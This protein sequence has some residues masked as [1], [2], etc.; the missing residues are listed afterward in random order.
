[1]L[2]FRRLET[3]LKEKRFLDGL[4][5]VNKELTNI[6]E[7]NT[8][9]YVKEW[10]STISSAEEC[11]T[12]IR[13]T[14]EGLMHQ[15][16]A[17]L[18]RYSY[19]KFP[20]LKSVSLY[21]DELIDERK[22][23]DA[24]KLLKDSLQDAAEDQI[25][26]DT[27]S[28]TYFTLVRC[29]LEMKRNEEA[30]QYMKK[31]EQYSK[32]PLFDKWGY[33]Y[34]QTGEWDKAE[35][36]LLAGKQSE[37]CQ[38]LATYLLSQLYAYRGE[39]QQALR[40]IDDAMEK[41]PQVPYFYFEKVKNLVDLQCYEE[42]IDL[43]D[44]IN[45]MLPYHAYKNYFV[46]LRAEALYKMNKSEELLALLKK[47]T[48]LKDSIYHNIEKYPDGKKVQL[49][50]V[51][52]VQ[53]DN[54]CVP[55]SLEM[56]LRLW[57][58]ER[59]Q[60][61]VANHIFDV[62]GSKFSD[63]VLYLEELGYVCRYFKG[64]EKLYKQ[65]IDQGIPVLLSLDIEHASHV[66]VL[67]GYDEQL[68]SFSIQDP[69]F[70][71]PLLV[72]Y[73]KFQERYRYTDYLSIVFVPKEKVDQ[74]LCLSSEEDA[75]FRKLFTLTDHLE[76]QDKLG[77]EKLVAFLQEQREI[78]YT[79]LYA[80]KH[81]DVEVNQEFILSCV[82]SLMKVYPDSDFVK[83][84][85][86]Q[87]F[88][89]LRD[90]EQAADMLQSVQKKKNQALY[91]FIAGRYALEKENYEEAILSFQ[92]SLQLDAD[93]PVAWS[94]LALS[95]MYMDQSEKGL[96]MSHIAIQRHPE[97]FVLVNHGLILMDLE[98][99]EQ[100]YHMFNTLLKD[101]KYEAHI[102]YERARCARQL[103]KLYLAIKGLHIAIQLDET[104]PYSYEELS[105][106]YEYD[107]EDEKSAE[108]ILLQGISKCEDPSTIYV[109][110]GDLY[111]QSDRFDRAEEIY[112]RC[113]EE[114]NQDVFAHLGLVQIYMAQE[115]YEQ[116]KQYIVSVE[117]QFEKNHDFL[118]NAGMALW[119]AEVELG[120]KEDQLKTVLFM[121]EDGIRYLQNNIADV[122]EEYV[123]RIEGTSFVQ[124]SIAFLKQLAKERAEHIE[125]SC[126][127]GILYESLGQYGQAMKRYYYAI[128][129]QS[130][131]LPY[132]RLGETYM[133][134]EQIE[135]AKKAYE[136]C[137]EINSQFTVGHFKLAE[138]YAMEE[139]MSKE[140]YHMLQAMKQ[141]P[142]GVDMEHLAQLSVEN[143]LHKEL[144]SELLKLTGRVAEMWRL[145]A[146]AYVYGAAG[147]SEK[148]Q[149]L[150]EEALQMDK[151]HPEVIFHYAKVLA[152]QRNPKAI[153]LVTSVMKRDIHN[154]RAFELYVQV[155]EQ[156]RKLP[157]IRDAL[158][159]LPITKKERSFTFMYTATA[160]ANRLA[161]KQQNEQPKKSIF[162]RAFYRMKNR[163]KEI[164]SLTM[165]IDLFE[166]SL[167]LNA[168][169]SLAA[170]RLA[171]FYEN[172]NMI[173]EAIEVLQTALENVWDFDAAQQFATLL[174][175]HGD[176][177][178]DMIR[179]ALRLTKQM[180][181]EQPHH[182]DV[183]VLQ[184]HALFELGDEKKA[185]KI[186][187]QLVETMP[188]VSRGFLALADIYRSQERFKEAIN[189]LE[190]GLTH[191]PHE[192]AIYLALAASYHQD[193]RT[194]KAEELMC[195]VLSFDPS[196]LLVR[197]N[198]ACYLAMLNRNEEAKA[199]LETVLQEDETGLFAEIAEEDEDLSEV[200]GAVKR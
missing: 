11:Y 146:L 143:Q 127:V 37:E 119:D 92:S 27:L 35:Q 116:A 98:C 145:D 113:L 115:Q 90:M 118:I 59:T 79:W 76:E 70:L 97:R 179:D 64:T 4:Y 149:E 147:D 71:E 41:F 80:I 193:G 164:Y 25:D 88:I 199:E 132:Y 144:L 61:E 86:A 167:K 74:L 34:I 157:Q 162:T 174:L 46:H 84:H 30:L 128:N 60:D 69:N 135:Q 176:G 73:D 93:Q 44:Q 138:I 177:N 120:A 178:E 77:I 28:K 26:S 22:V 45:R 108:D 7:V 197:Y 160:I 156:Q 168:K 129:Q 182:Y 194:E 137:L 78:P 180:L 122:L 15:Y 170:Q 89:R 125:Y 166:T 200:W 53:K 141:D 133:A 19:K 47:E 104:A 192:N 99:Y 2:E 188:F 196:D 181:Q 52:I 12:L 50:L 8:L 172:G 169:N 43:L 51:P 83:L 13:L 123:N 159:L 18:T 3:C 1:M 107:L 33:F 152:K 14:D 154:E 161:E 163:A 101:Y 140:Q 49:P 17:F 131:T 72:E 187:L 63:T 139:N 175:N 10:L 54:Y 185:E 114:N 91:H 198:H 23:L 24:E 65:L 40:L 158:H 38:E 68:Q 153:S 105:E 62:T 39:H 130:S 85:S 81:L 121:L 16:S 9:S 87:C 94:F 96:E 32:R 57:K 36:S 134:L 184:S 183:L 191:H 110:L 111:F 21:C 55:A 56:M 67:A 165:V 5:D 117:K 142:L 150:V 186:C 173:A 151:E 95:Y 155:M 106:I 112:K 82:Q 109:R 190:K 6:R 66:Q 29:L 58:E 75:Y 148:E 20:S 31:A 171:E 195:H 136:T 100:A 126:Y 124:R 42:M 48:C 102:W 189:M 103:G